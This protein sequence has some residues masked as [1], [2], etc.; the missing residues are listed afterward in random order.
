MDGHPTNVKGKAVET[1]E[2]EDEDARQDR[3]RTCSLFRKL[4]CYDLPF[5]WRRKYPPEAEYFI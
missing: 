4:D 5:R 1:L 3:L 2:I